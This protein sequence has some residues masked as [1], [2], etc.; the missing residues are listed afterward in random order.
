[1]PPSSIITVKQEI[2][3]KYQEQ[4]QQ[5]ITNE[6][7]LQA[8]RCFVD[9]FLGKPKNRKTVSYKKPCKTFKKANNV[10]L[11]NRFA[12]KPPSVIMQTARKKK[13]IVRQNSS[14]MKKKSDEELLVLK[15][16]LPQTASGRNTALS[17]AADETDNLSVSQPYYPPST[18][19]QDNLDNVQDSMAMDCVFEDG[20]D[21][22]QGHDD[23]S[24]M[25][26]V[27]EISDKDIEPYLY[28]Q[29]LFVNFNLFV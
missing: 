19:Q 8:A 25:L 16:F 1:M 4:K 12:L 5:C 9:A 10:K 13:Q 15:S 23:S 26:A 7:C 20:W 27:P 11:D 6:H 17:I 3:E 28:S 14:K 29:E 2:Q 24:T 21:F 22:Q 18:Q